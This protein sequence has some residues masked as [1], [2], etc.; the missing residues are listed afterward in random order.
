MFILIQIADSRL[1]LCL[2]SPDC[3]PLTLRRAQ[4]RGGVGATGGGGVGG[5][6]VAGGGSGGGRGGG[7]ARGGGGRDEPLHVGRAVRV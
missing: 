6:G 7:A 5:G 4:S 3:E 2:W 1:K